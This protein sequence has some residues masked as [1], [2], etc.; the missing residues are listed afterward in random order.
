L[1]TPERTRR[2]QTTN[3]LT[4]LPQKSQRRKSPFQIWHLIK[5][6]NLPRKKYLTAQTEWKSAIK[7]EKQQQGSPTTEIHITTPLQAILKQ[8]ISS[9]TQSINGQQQLPTV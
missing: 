2:Q 1:V 7:E 8:E 9:P 6:P 4:P 5:E 3:S